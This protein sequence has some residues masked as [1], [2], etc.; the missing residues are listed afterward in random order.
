MILKHYIDR[1][2]DSPNCRIFGKKNEHVSH[3]VSECNELPQNE[4]K[5]LRDDKIVALLHWQ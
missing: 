1:T 4:N 2:T 3:I 5:K